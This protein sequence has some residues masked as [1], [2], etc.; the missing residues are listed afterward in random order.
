MRVSLKIAKPL[1]T[2]DACITSIPYEVCEEGRLHNLIPG[3]HGTL[4]ILYL[5]QGNTFVCCVRK[6]RNKTIKSLY[7]ECSFDIVFGVSQNYMLCLKM[8]LSMQR[9]QLNQISHSCEKGQNVL[10]WRKKTTTV[11][12]H[13]LNVPSTLD[14]AILRC[15]LKSRGVGHFLGYFKTV[16]NLILTKLDPLNSPTSTLD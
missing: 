9:N 8:L 2:T 11:I 7:I 12:W 10:F 6:C 14:Y 15:K 4:T 16:C 1:R 13:I 3:Q 5:Y